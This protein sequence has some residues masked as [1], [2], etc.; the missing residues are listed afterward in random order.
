VIGLAIAAVFIL[1]NGFFVA[2]EFALVKVRA[3][4]LHA[5]ARSGDRRAILARQ[6][7][8][9]LDRYLGV[10][11]LGVTLASLG[12]GW[13]G[14]PAVTRVFEGA[15]IALTGHA[16]G[17][18]AHLGVVAVAFFLLTS[19]HILF[20][21]LVPKLVAIQRS[22]RTALFVA[23][24]VRVI[25]IAF[26]PLLWVLEAATRVIL[27]A[28]GLSADVGDHGALPEAEI[29]GILAA[30]TGRS[31]RGREKSELVE[32]VI[33]FS[34]RTARH[35]M[36]PRV[37]VASLPLCTRGDDAA[38]FLRKQQFSRVILTKER[39]LDEVAGY[40]YAKDFWLDPTVEQAHDLSKVR[41]DVLF[42]PET[43]GAV[44]VL[45][46]MQR[47]ETPIAVVV[48]EYGGTSGIVTMEDLLEEIVGEI[49]DELDEEP[50][51][52]TKVEGELAAWDVDGRAAMEELR[53][54]GMHVEDADAA[55]SV[56]AVVLGRLGRLPRARDR[57]EIGN[58]TAE[59]I[60]VN[61]RRVVR[62][63]VWLPKTEPPS[64][65]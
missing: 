61:R 21:E 55:E 44:D 1:L 19:I 33:R 57:V 10:T 11:Q 45:R 38:I 59:V 36:V 42:V 64:S 17:E 6:V 15:G 5:R 47:E 50:A 23:I 26:R 39:S 30:S 40:L 62:V 24:P 35:A 22:E 16:L 2:A 60:A 41:R 8:S 32:R 48:D 4:Q 28:M 14:E 43:Q 31:P 13:I 56:G 53:S 9:R 52:I 34:Q 37:D 27:R 49:K 63:R 46:N 20:G 3:T 29:L 65:S 7:I 58:A 54:L 18:Y 25:Y 51:K 12:L